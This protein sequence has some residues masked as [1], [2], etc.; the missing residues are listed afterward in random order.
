MND[1][2]HTPFDF[3][4]ALG[5]NQY[6]LDQINWHPHHTALYAE[7]MADAHTAADSGVVVTPASFQN[8]PNTYTTSRLLFQKSHHTYDNF[9]RSELLHLSATASLCAS[10]AFVC[11]QA[12]FTQQ[13]THIEIM[14]K[15]SGVEKLAFRCNIAAASPNMAIQLPT[16][17]QTARRLA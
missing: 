12:V 1:L 2:S 16:F 3:H 10:I 9:F 14:R 15:D 17:V 8:C 5:S 6:T 4:A 11:L 13:E 7:S